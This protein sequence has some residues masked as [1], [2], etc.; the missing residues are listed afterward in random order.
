MLLVS[1]T[2]GVEGGGI[3]VVTLEGTPVFSAG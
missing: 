3:G 1:N 2:P